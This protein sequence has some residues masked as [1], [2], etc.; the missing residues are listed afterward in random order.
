MFTFES[1]RIIPT[2]RRDVTGMLVRIGVTIPKYIYIY[3]HIYIHIYIYPYFRLVNYS[4]SR[5][6]FG[7]FKE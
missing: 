1:G 5:F 2:S 4:F 7:F 6:F 3:I